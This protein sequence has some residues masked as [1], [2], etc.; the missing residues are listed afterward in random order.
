MTRGD[1]IG[2][3]TSYLYAFGLLFTVEAI[4]RWLR[5]EQEFTRKIIHIGAGLWIWGILALFDH[6]YWGIIP[7]ASFILL[8]Y[9]FYRRQ[10]F[11]AMDTERSSLGTVYFAFSITVLFAWLWRTEGGTDRVPFA[12]GAVMT[13]TLGDAMA[14][15]IGRRWGAHQ[16]TVLGHARSWEGSAAMA[17]VS[18]ASIGVTLA[19][20]PASTLSPN[21]VALSAGQVIG[22]S[23][24]A[25][26]VATLVEA[27]SPAGTDNLS[28]PLLTGLL[29]VVLGAG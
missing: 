15:V 27:L 6:W 2:L 5:W 9:M 26:A 20:L 25:A 12:A 3:V 4:G 13:M 23:L 21:S 29:M 16:Y 19:L 11:K 22:T 10:T 17:M 1:V 8:N 18:L 28:V 24:A 14:S 7:F